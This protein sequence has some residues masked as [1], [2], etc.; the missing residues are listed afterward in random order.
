MTLF[1]II[2]L[3]LKTSSIAASKSD[4][5]VFKIIMMESPI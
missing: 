2:V 4:K 3:N 5:P 1:L